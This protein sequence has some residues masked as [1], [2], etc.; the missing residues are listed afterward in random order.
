MHY[1]GMFGTACWICLCG[2]GGTL[3]CTSLYIFFFAKISRIQS[4]HSPRLQAL[5]LL[6][7]YFQYPRMI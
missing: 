6:V 7:N 1:V 2:F 5:N 4:T 3:V